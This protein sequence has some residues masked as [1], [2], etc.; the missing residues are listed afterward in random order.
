VQGG[1]AAARQDQAL[2]SLSDSLATA[3]TSQ[4]RGG[5]GAAK[6]GR[7]SRRGRGRRTRR[8]KR[9]REKRRRRRQR[10][11]LARPSKK[12]RLRFK[13]LSGTETPPA[14]T[15]VVAACAQVGICNSLPRRR[16]WSRKAVPCTLCRFF[17]VLDLVLLY[18]FSACVFLD[19]ESSLH[20]KYVEQI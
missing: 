12:C 18:L 4:Q 16:P 19:K 20:K 7:R 15:A 13:K 17:F 1:R 9:R 8:G 10:T 11:R 2:S 3:P 5:S 14:A 6:R